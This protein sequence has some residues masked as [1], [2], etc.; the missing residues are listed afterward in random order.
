MNHWVLF[1]GQLESN[2]FLFYDPLGITSNYYSCS[3]SLSSFLLY[4]PE[5]EFC[6]IRCTIRQKGLPLQ[7]NTYDC[8][9][10]ICQVAKKC[11]NGY[12]FENVNFSG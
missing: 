2:R 3:P 9:L 7:N 12:D 1:V 4:L 5:K 6:D 10:F 8:G 11:H